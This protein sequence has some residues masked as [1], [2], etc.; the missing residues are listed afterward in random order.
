MT[1]LSHWLFMLAVPSHAERRNCTRLYMRD[2]LRPR[3]HFH[4][5]LV[6]WITPTRHIEISMWTVK[7]HSFINSHQLEEKNREIVFKGWFLSEIIKSSESNPS[8]DPT[9]YSCPLFWLHGSG[10][11]NITINF[12]II[13]FVKTINQMIEKEIHESTL[14]IIIFK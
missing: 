7:L 9:F 11:R 8:N 5:T 10:A 13:H 4:S 2:A 12:F 1:I 3:E 6:K 14:K